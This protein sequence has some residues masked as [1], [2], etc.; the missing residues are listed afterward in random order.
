MAI[1]DDRDSRPPE[2]TL[3]EKR[4][5]A[6]QKRPGSRIPVG[7]YLGALLAVILILAAVLF[8]AASHTGTGGN[9]QTTGGIVLL[10]STVPTLL[11]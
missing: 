4:P 8:I 7:V 10:L 1:N 6:P 3:F 11:G 5:D 9:G 2:P